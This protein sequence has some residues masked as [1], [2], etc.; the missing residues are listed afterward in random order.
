MEWK[1]LNTFDLDLG[2]IQTSTSE[3]DSNG[4]LMLKQHINVYGAY[5][6]K[7]LNIHTFTRTSSPEHV[8]GASGVTFLC[9]R[10]FKQHDQHRLSFF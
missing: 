9:F 6:C 2:V 3:L 8:A 5:G 4:G 10:R 7:D 1:N